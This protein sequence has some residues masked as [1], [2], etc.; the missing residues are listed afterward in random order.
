MYTVAEVG[1][2]SLKIRAWAASNPSSKKFKDTW[3]K[4]LKDV[5]T[6]TRCA[7]G[8]DVGTKLSP[9]TRIGGKAHRILTRL[10]NMMDREITTSVTANTERERVYQVFKDVT[11]GSWEA[12]DSLSSPNH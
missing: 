12:H 5:G 1:I 3:K 7:N 9:G 4:R 6:A 2:A 10:L 8:A 11:D